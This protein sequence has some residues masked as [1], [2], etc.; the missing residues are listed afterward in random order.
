M[1]VLDGVAVDV[2]VDA[3]IEGAGW[4]VLTSDGEAAREVVDVNEGANV[5]VVDVDGVAADEVGVDGIAAADGVTSEGVDVL[6]TVGLGASCASGATGASGMLCSS[7]LL[8]PSFTSDI[9][10]VGERAS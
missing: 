7:W 8:P 9:V 2:D 1:I 3:A 5:D 10:V 6:V 4:D